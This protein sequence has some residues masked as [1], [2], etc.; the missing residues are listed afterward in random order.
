LTQKECGFLTNAVDAAK[1]QE[2][3]YQQDMADIICEGIIA[4]LE[5]LE[6]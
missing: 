6:E 1:L 5:E 2:E 3:A 4:S